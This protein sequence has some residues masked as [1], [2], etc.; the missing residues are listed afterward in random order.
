MYRGVSLLKSTYHFS[1]A[2]LKLE[3]LGLELERDERLDAL[4]AGRW[5][6][7]RAK[8]HRATSDDQLLAWRLS[9]L[10]RE[11]KPPRVLE[12]GAGK[13]TVTLIHSAFASQATYV[14]IESLSESYLLSLK[15]RRLNR[16]EERFTPLCGDL[17]DPS[18]IQRALEIYPEYDL[19]CGAP[20][21]MPLGAGVLPKDEQRARG[22]FE[23]KGG[24]EDYFR[25]IARCLS[26][27]AESRGVI[28]MDGK[29][30]QRALAAI[31]TIPQLKLIRIIE[32]APRPHLPPTYEIFE[33]AWQ[34]P[35]DSHKSLSQP[36]PAI[37]HSRLN[38]RDLEG[39]DW[40]DEY[41]KIRRRLGL[42]KPQFPLTFVPARLQSRRLPHKALLDI[43]GQPM[44][45]RVTE[46]LL[47]LLPTD[48]LV[49]VSDDESVLSA[50]LK[51]KCDSVA[52]RRLIVN[53]PCHSGSQRVLRAHETLLLRSPESKGRAKLM[54]HQS[55]GRR[56]THPLRELG[57][58][59]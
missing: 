27:R 26:P 50:S 31:S 52:V 15:N 3:S 32:V 33:V 2:S 14:G 45:A 1:Q 48:R 54:D 16:L 6:I 34:T 7:Q 36:L 21:F 40:S 30:H 53:E 5:I 22:R 28:L 17:R 51:T 55:T 44:I 11:E 41:M 43:E 19:I 58:A 13:G 35:Y 49:I 57:S 12:L 10:W 8:G 38:F 39:E 9:A 4:C 23:L 42:S 18:V 47:N 25:A 37:H 59:R 29:S 24:V 46:R 56:T 20:P